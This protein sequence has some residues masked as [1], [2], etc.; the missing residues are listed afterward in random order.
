M[1]F[2]GRFYYKPAA[3]YTCIKWLFNKIAEEEEEEGF[4][5]YAPFHTYCSYIANFNEG[6]RDLS[7]RFTKINLFY[8]LFQPAPTF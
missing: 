1:R 7:F 8:F 5:D 2:C 4:W 3:S 6:I